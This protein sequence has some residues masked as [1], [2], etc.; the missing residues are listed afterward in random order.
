MR[1]AALLVLGVFLG[2]VGALVQTGTTSLGSLT[3]PTG[4][5]L[6]LATLVPL[7]RAG[8]WWM[9]SRWGAIALSLGWLAATLL[10][11]TTT[12]GGDLVIS[13]GTRQVAYL[14]GGT[15]LLS[16]ACGY[17]LLAPEDDEPMAVAAASDDD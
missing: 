10:M 8:A 13:S 3:L 15:I 9:D 1:A 17:P 5:L 12:S 4:T 6:V 11:G 16:A 14:V 7:A 2:M